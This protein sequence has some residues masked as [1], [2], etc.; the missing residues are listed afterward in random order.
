[1]PQGTEYVGVQMMDFPHSIRGFTVMVDFETF[2]IFINSR[3][4]YDIQCEA[5]DHEIG[6]IDRKDFDKMYSVHEIE[7]IG[8]AIAG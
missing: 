4:S 7:N 1:M 3:L 6:H 2:I 5:Y 8:H